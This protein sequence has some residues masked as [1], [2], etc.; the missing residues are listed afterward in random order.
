MPEYRG[1]IKRI[2]QEG[3][4]E[5][6]I[7]PEQAGIPGAPGVNVCHCASEGSK[8]TFKAENRVGAQ[9][10]D[11][12]LITRKISGIIKN[13]F[14]FIGVPVLGAMLGLTGGLV[15][16]ERFDWAVWALVAAGLLGL[17]SGVGV[18]IAI[19]RIESDHIEFTV[20][21]VIE[22]G[23]AGQWEAGEKASCFF[24]DPGTCE[25]CVGR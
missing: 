21:R 10:G 25:K 9:A 19:Y 14:V 15:L 6:E 16:T 2:L 5:I 3:I 7:V 12:V 22:P 23:G 4:V 1:V 20:A 13:I 24:A 11:G 8:V 18:C 17:V